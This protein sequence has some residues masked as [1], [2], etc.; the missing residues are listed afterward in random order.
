MA[1]E[2]KQYSHLA[3]EY[4]MRI[5]TFLEHH[6]EQDLS[7][8]DHYVTEMAQDLVNRILEEEKKKNV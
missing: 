4:A 7:H 1:D 6:T 5:S 3:F 2:Q 8:L